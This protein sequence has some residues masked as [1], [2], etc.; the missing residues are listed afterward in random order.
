[1]T[2]EQRENVRRYLKVRQGRRRR[3]IEGQK[4]ACERCSSRSDLEWH[5]RIPW[6]EGGDDS[7]ENLQVLCQPCHQAEHAQRDDFRKNG[8]WGGLVSACVR[9]ERLGRERF[10]DE[11]RTLALRRW[12]A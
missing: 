12:A 1:M 3:P 9:E 6:S 2:A 11:M 8:Q 7:P 10:C 5:H 4:V